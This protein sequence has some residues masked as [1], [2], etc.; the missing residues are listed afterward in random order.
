MVKAGNVDVFGRNL[1]H[2]L[3]LAAQ[4]N[5]LEIGGGDPVEL[6]QSL[7]VGLSLR[8]KERTGEDL[9]N[10]VVVL[11]DEYDAPIINNVTNEDL[12]R[13]IRSEL[14]S[15]YSV[16]KGCEKY[17]RFVFITGVTKF[18]QTSLF[19]DLNNLV[20]LTLKEKFA[21]ICGFTTEEFDSLFAEHLEAALGHM[22]TK[23]RLSG[24][25]TADDLRREILARYDGYSWDGETRVLNPWSV[26]NCLD[27]AKLANYWFNSGNPAFLLDVIKKSPGFFDFLEK[28]PKITDD[29]NAVDVGSFDPVPLMF[30]TG[31]LTVD[32]EDSTRPEP[33]YRLRYP[34]L[35]VIQALA[36]LLLALEPPFGGDNVAMRLARAMADSLAAKDAPGLE[37][38]FAGL[39]N[40]FPY[41][42]HNPLESYYHSLFIMAMKVAGWEIQSEVAKGGGRLD[43]ILKTVDG[44]TL[45]I[46][47]KYHPPSKIAGW[48]ED[49]PEDL[50]RDEMDQTAQVAL[51]Q[52]ETKG[53]ARELVAAKR[54]VCMIAI[55][56][57]GRVR[58]L[59]KFK[60]C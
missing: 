24:D 8:H 26:L 32:G 44:E 57:G 47:F 15:F 28:P 51:D 60:K 39:L 37:A 10:N 33:A 25:A 23:G 58:V 59:A 34:N 16:L 1:N 53:Y 21:G 30:Q 52:I 50:K 31:Y 43:A 41:H 22:K 17:L 11:I 29:I 6:M 54:R 35:E 12:A 55:V 14:K 42:L 38:A 36:P 9:E 13:A 4:I 45:V 40:I 2:Q 46:E 27:N 5:G 19:S 3:K 49:V 56:I 7:I 18:A 48:L 20:D